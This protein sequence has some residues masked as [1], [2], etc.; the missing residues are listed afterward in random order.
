MMITF[1]LEYYNHMLYVSGYHEF[2]HIN[3]TSGVISVDQELDRE[4]PEV[5]DLFGVLNLVVLVCTVS[6]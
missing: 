6:T 3:S 1:L 4:D 2:F 5:L